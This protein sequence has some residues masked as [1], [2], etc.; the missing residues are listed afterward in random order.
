MHH[1]WKQQKQQHQ[2]IFKP[3]IGDHIMDHISFMWLIVFS[4][5]TF[6]FTKIVS[7]YWFN[8]KYMYTLF[9]SCTIIKIRVW[10]GAKF[11]PGKIF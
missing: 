6:Y 7:I 4:F 11:I 9:I 3:E 8:L 1:A 10:G 2:G 5:V